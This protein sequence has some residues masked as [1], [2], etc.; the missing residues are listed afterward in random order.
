M[1]VLALAS[2]LWLTACGGSGHGRDAYGL[3]DGPVENSS[4]GERPLTIPALREWAP[5]P[6]SFSLRP[7][8][9][10]LVASQDVALLPVAELFAEDLRRAHGLRTAITTT[11]TRAPSSGDIRLALG[12]I[13]PQIGEEGYRLRLG[14]EGAVIR[15]RSPAGVFYGTRTV[16]QLLAQ[17]DTIPAG[18]ARDWPRYPERGLMLDTGR[19]HL[20]AE[21]IKSRIRELAFLKLNY[22]HLHLSDDPG[23]RIESKR[24][25]EIVSAEHITQAELHEILAL[26]E[27]HHVLVV[28][29]ID[30]PA[31]MGAI[32]APYPQ[33]Q[34]VDVFGRA[35]PNKLDITNPEARAFVRSL[36]EEFL[37]LFPGRYWHGGADEYLRPD[38]YALHPQLEAY[39]RSEYGSEATAKDAVHGFVNWVD[40]IVRAAGKTTRIWHDGLTGGNAVT[41]NPGIVVEWWTNVS[42]LSDSMPPKPQALLDKGHRIM[43]AGFFPTYYATWI[44]AALFLRADMRTAYESWSAHEFYGPIVINSLIKTPPDLVDPDE[45]RHLGS[46]IHVWND[47]PGTE[48]EAQIAAELRMRLRML[49]QKTWESPL[50]VPGYAEFVQIADQVGAPP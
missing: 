31:H 4:L 29:E 30:M 44:P 22:L 5:A 13:D 1:R 43:N 7:D 32:L 49:A 34:L 38:E 40:S 24:H 36:V 16:L 33:Y 21:W 37:A 39:A 14:A 10:I 23:F 19:Q 3:V 42:P 12:S 6:G 45:P 27:R 26:A 28:P 9:R 41:V 8:A 48:D 18:D 46:K 25:P 15:A 50:L 47:V 2:L 20:S 11:P 35:S 17:H